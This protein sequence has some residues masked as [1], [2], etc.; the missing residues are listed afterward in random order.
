[1]TN[2]KRDFCPLHRCIACV[3]RDAE[4]V[5][6]DYLELCL[7]CLQSRIQPVEPGKKFVIVLQITDCGYDEGQDG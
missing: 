3:H 5:L 1:M 2:P 7:Y 6:S 4:V